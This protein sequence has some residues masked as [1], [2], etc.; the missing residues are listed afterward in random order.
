MKKFGYVNG[1]YRNSPTKSREELLMTET[2]RNFVVGN[3]LASDLEA[4]LPDL[5][6]ADLERIME[7]Y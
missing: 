1:Y 7:T 5:V 2:L 3:E 4:K 6:K